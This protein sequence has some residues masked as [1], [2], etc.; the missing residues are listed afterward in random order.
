MVPHPHNIE[1]RERRTFGIPLE[2]GAVFEDAVRVYNRT[3]QPLNLFVY[4]ADAEAGADGTISVGFRGS[5]PKGVGAWVNLPRDTINLPGRGEALVR[6]RIEVRSDD[7]TPALGAIVVENAERGI[8]ADLAQRLQIVIRTSSPNSPTTSVRVRPLLLRSP[9]IIV[10]TLGLVVAFVIIW[11]GA[12]RARKPK[13]TVVPTGGLREPEVTPAASKPV[14]R[15]LGEESREPTPSARRRPVTTAAR[16]S[17]ATRPERPRRRSDESDEEL[18]DLRPI[19]D[20]MLTAIDEAEREPE[21]AVDQAP[22]RAQAASQA[23][24]LQREAPGREDEERAPLYPAGQDLAA[25]AE[26]RCEVIHG[27]LDRALFAPTSREHRALDVAFRDRCPRIAVDLRQDEPQDSTVGHMLA[28]LADAV[29]GHDAYPPDQR[30]DLGVGRDRLDDLDTVRRLEVGRRRL[31]EHLAAVADRVCDGLDEAVVRTDGEY[32]RT[33][34]DAERIDGF[35]W[36]LRKSCHSGNDCGTSWINSCG[37][38]AQW[39]SRGLLSLRL[40]VRAPGAPL[41]RCMLSDRD[42]LPSA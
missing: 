23:E 28:Q 1:G 39:E 10:A 40:R 16:S 4:A 21:P 31:H 20:D 24:G 15:R 7:P 22:E 5:R 26:P 35:F 27:Q 32:G 33:A 18:P 36:V 12:R 38:L 11:L 9:W 34:A 14:L 2:T 29:N 19:L 37:A 42:R 30:V 3:D 41:L 25:P 13:D 17:R 8:A 6:F